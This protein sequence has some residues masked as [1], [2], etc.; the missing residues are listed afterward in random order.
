M[1]ER[2]V[3]VPA[4]DSPELVKTVFLSLKWHSGFAA[5]Q[6][7]KNIKALHLAAASAGY[8]NVLEVS[9]KSEKNRGQKLSAFYL[10]VK[11]VQLGEIPLDVRFSRQQGL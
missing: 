11:S 5:V 7:E 8:Q 1:A 9:T 2:P 6:K 10:K 4:P 3:F